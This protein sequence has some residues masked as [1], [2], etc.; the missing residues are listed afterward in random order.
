MN[1][2]SFGLSHSCA[3][4]AALCLGE[5]CSVFTKGVLKDTALWPCCLTFLFAHS[6]MSK[7]EWEKQKFDKTIG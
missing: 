3:V 4:C 5:I 6:K 1:A 2:Y 7:A